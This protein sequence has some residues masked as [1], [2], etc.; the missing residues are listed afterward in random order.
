MVSWIAFS[1]YIPPLVGRDEVG[2]E[3]DSVGDIDFHAIVGH[4]Q[5][6]DDNGRIGPS[7]DV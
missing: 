6:S 4:V 3:S 5:P 7:V 2:D 1:V